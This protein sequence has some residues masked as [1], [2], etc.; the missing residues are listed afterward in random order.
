MKVAALD[1]GTN[2]FL[3]LIAEGTKAGISHVHK[4][5][6]QVVRLGQEV[7]KTGE[8]HPDA[9]RRAR[10]CLVDFKKE[11]EEQGVDRVLAVATSAARDA[12]NG[13]EL[14]KMGHD[15]D[16]PIEI[17]A[18]QDEARITFQGATVGL[19]DQTKTSL[20]I[21]VGGGSTEFILGQGERILFGESLNVGG[22]RLTERFISEQPVPEGDRRALNKFIGEQIAAILPSLSHEKIDQIIAVAGTPTSLAAIEVGG[23]D[24]HKVDG[25]FLTKERLAFWVQEF[26]STTVDEKKSKYQLGARADIIYAGASILLSAIEA[27]D[28]PGMIVSIKGVRYGVALELLRR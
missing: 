19:A 26:A 17:I 4:D 12:R 24:A 25:F 21:D 1:L 14:F 2:T 7:D 18:G 3:C 10:A 27:L 28:L 8:F 5:L 23:F 22:V 15:L 6:A 11:I 13:M 20:V 16:I 9:L